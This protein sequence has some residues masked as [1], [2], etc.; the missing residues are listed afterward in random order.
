MALSG[1]GGARFEH[2]L[3]FLFVIANRSVLTFITHATFLNLFLLLLFFL[4]D[5]NH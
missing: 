5:F 2:P 3:S 1:N 4:Q